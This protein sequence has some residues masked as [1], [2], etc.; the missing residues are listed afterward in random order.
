MKK[1]HDTLELIEELNSYRKN[2]IFSNEEILEEKEN[3]KEFDVMYLRL[4]KTLKEIR[5]NVSINDDVT[6][7]QL[8]QLHLI[9][10]DYIWHFDQIHS[11]IKEIIK[12]YR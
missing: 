7:E 2:S 12:K 8:I 6:I 1:I 4:D 10:S 9:Y 3:L 5:K 11:M